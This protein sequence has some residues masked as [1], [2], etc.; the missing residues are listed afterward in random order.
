VKKGTGYSRYSMAE[1]E[2]AVI[3]E[4]LLLKIKDSSLINNVIEGYNE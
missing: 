1:K 4:Y 3:K 2:E